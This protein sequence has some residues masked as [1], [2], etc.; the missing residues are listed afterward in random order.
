MWPSGS[1]D[2]QPHRCGAHAH[3]E[4][5]GGAGRH[6][7]GVQDHAGLPAAGK[8]PATR[9]DRRAG[10]QLVQPCVR[11]IRGGGGGVRPGS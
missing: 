11:L 4:P 8:H 1:A 6:V 7:W 5:A 3:D 9:G 10:S 2:V